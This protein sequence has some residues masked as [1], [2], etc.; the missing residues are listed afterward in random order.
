MCY[1]FHVSGETAFLGLVRKNPGEKQLIPESNSLYQR[2]TNATGERQ[3]LTMRNSVIFIL[4]NR[5]ATNVFLSTNVKM[6]FY[7][8]TV[9][10]IVV[11]WQL[12]I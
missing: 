7:R 9:I 8:L 11:D 12:P 2:K 5:E 3:L 6:S 1:I 4:Q 10:L